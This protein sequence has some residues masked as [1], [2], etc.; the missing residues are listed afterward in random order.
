MNSPQAPAWWHERRESRSG[1][2]N[3][4]VSAGRRGWN[5]WWVRSDFSDSL[6]RKCL[7][8]I[9]FRNWK[10]SWKQS[11]SIWWQNQGRNLSTKK[12]N[13]NAQEESCWQYEHTLTSFSV[14]AEASTTL[15]LQVSNKSKP[16]DVD[17]T[18]LGILG[19][20]SHKEMKVRLWHQ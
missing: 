18:N 5:S 7:L 6:F 11:I 8:C 12:K 2:M 9:F 10:M 19:L 4:S 20:Y 17:V 14:F 16:Q 13:A 3:E 15:I 1:S